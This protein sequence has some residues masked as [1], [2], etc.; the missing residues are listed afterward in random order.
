MERERERGMRGGVV[1]IYMMM[2]MKMKIRMRR[3]ERNG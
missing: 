1:M 2:S 3:S